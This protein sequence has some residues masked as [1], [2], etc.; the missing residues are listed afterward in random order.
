MQMKRYQ[1]RHV[2]FYM[3]ILL[4]TLL[5]LLLTVSFTI[6]QD[7]LEIIE[8]P[9]LSGAGPH[10]VAPAPDGIVWYTAQASGALGRF[11]PE[12]GESRH[13][14]LG[15]SSRPH[16]VIVGPDAAPW[17]TDSGLNA[18]VRV[19]PETE[20][21]EVF[22]LPTGSA[23]LNTATFDGDGIL[24]FTGQNGV[25]G[26]LDPATSE[27]EVFDAPRG[28]GPYG[29]ATTPDGEVYYA[30]L[31]GSHIAHINR[32]TGDATVIEP[33]TPNQ[34][35]RRVWSD[36]EGRIWVSEWDAGRLGMYDPSS[37]TWQEWELPGTNP[38]P[39]AVYVDVLD[40]VWLSDFSANALV[41]FDPDTETF[42]VFPLENAGASVRQI[43]GR[44]G[45]VWG[46]ESGTDHL[47][48]VMIGEVEQ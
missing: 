13:I 6:A 36:S 43:L 42:E 29:I 38:R 9:I 33:P 27:L 20:V 47:V 5:T 10:D 11:D 39:Y 12:T 40:D 22:P 1:H 16:G 28:R 31:A 17:I 21:I 15:A 41:R 2:A 26:R 30:S 25:Y 14:S 37:E 18:I 19:D 24:W 4:L 8:Y 7:T 45:E 35:A 32:E 46:A 23:N 44:N 48:V 34:G 3:G